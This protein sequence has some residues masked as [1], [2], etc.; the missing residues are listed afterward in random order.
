MMG[1]K[2]ASGGLAD[3]HSGMRSGVYSLWSRAH[4]PLAF[5]LCS[6]F[7]R[8]RVPGTP[9]L[10]R[11]TCAAGGP[12]RT[13]DRSAQAAFLRLRRPDGVVPH[14][15]PGPPAALASPATAKSEQA[16]SPTSPIDAIG[17]ALWGMVVVPLAANR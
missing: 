2:A 6:S 12:G 5:A 14:S 8:R 4:R 13:A 3:A 15:P 10:Q 1:S 11:G 17:P 16:L 7:A 9:R